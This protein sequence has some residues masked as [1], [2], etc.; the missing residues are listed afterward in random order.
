[1][2]LLLICLDV[3]QF[4]FCLVPMSGLSQP[5]LL[6][7]DQN[8]SM[9]WYNGTSG[10]PSFCHFLSVRRAVGTYDGGWGHKRQGSNKHWTEEV[11]V[12]PWCCW[13][14]ISFEMLAIWLLGHAVLSFKSCFQHL[15]I[16]LEFW[17]AMLVFHRKWGKKTASRHHLHK[18]SQTISFQAQSTH[19]CS[20][21]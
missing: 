10:T 21:V 16:G 13:R 2:W 12:W 6:R 8:C 14:M 19:I 11:T 4:F 18:M 9:D 5:Y 7:G 1:M 20:P 15:K 17:N 3:L